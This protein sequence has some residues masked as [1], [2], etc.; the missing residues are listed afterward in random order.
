M[1]WDGHWRGGRPGGT[2]EGDRHDMAVTGVQ[3][4]WRARRRTRWGRLSLKPSVE[5]GLRQDGGDA[6]TGGGMDVGA[7]RLRPFD[8]RL[9]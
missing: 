9:G 4:A 2:A 6:E 7:R 3:R 5:V 8:G 1:G